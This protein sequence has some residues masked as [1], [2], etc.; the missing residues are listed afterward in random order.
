MLAACENYCKDEERISKSFDRTKLRS[1]V[2]YSVEI[3]SAEFRNASQS[4]E[5]S[6][7]NHPNGVGQKS[8]QLP[9]DQPRLCSSY[10]LKYSCLI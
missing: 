6:I 2:F 7:I 8:R 3:F 1:G 9:V 4:I 10:L 5:L